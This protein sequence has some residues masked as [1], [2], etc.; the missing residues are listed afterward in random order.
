MTHSE[1]AVSGQTLS[2]PIRF[3]Q[4]VHM[5]IHTGMSASLHWPL[6]AQAHSWRLNKDDSNVWAHVYLGFHFRV[7]QVGPSTS[8]P[9]LVSS[10]QEKKNKT[11]KVR[12][13]VA[14]CSL[15]HCPPGIVGMLHFSYNKPHQAGTAGQTSTR[16]VVEDEWGW[17][18][19]VANRL[20][21]PLGSW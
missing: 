1:S 12:C 10:C 16:G 21:V 19:W 13:G 14:L 8:Y 9:L 3:E 17:M 11:K 5:C 4:S 18:P 20:P 6:Y 7:D 15:N 2:G